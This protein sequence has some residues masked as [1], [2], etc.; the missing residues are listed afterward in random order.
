MSERP[1]FISQVL[2]QTDTEDEEIIRKCGDISN[3]HRP[4]SIQPHGV[5]IGVTEPDLKVTHVSENTL[6]VF[7]LPYQDILDKTLDSV[8]NSN[9]LSVLKSN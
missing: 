4:G 1:L 2:P 5:Y 8:F 9:D 6:K 3:I 7:G